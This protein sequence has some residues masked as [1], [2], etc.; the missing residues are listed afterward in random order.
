MII[1]YHFFLKSAILFVSLVSLKPEIT[2][3]IILVNRP[4]RLASHYSFHRGLQST[5]TATVPPAVT[6][7]ETGKYSLRE[8]RFHALYEALL[9]YRSI[10]GHLDVPYKFEV[11]G[12]E[13][14][15]PSS[16][17]MKLGQ[18]VSRVRT[19]GDFKENRPQLEAIGFQYNL[20]RNKMS[21]SFERTM[22]AL[23]VYSRIHC[24]TLV[25]TLFVVPENDECMSA[26]FIVNY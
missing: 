19:R 2:E 9:V 20:T 13:N 12:D 6:N 22:Q 17:G 25:P 18:V 11:P 23:D 24:D 5:S 21:K 26:Y 7:G 8:Q 3:A 14:W 1:H 16:V 10:N 15:P 4:V